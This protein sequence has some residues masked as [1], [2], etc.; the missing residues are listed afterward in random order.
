MALYVLL[1]GRFPFRASSAACAFEDVLRE[2][3]VAHA[4]PGGGTS[5]RLRS[6]VFR[7]SLRAPESGAHARRAAEMPI[8]LAD[9]RHG[10]LDPSGSGSGS[11]SGTASAQ[12]AISSEAR[13]LLDRMLSLTP[14]ARPTMAGVLAHP[15]SQGRLDPGHERVIQAL[16]EAQR[17]SEA[18]MGDGGGAVPLPPVSVLQ[19]E[20]VWAEALEK[21]RR[22][23]FLHLEPYRD[24]PY[25]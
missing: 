23:V 12:L 22:W 10:Q 19:T 16:R 25:E 15:W 13:D 24:G 8:F 1:M 5:D 20:V 14:A 3:A 6:Y 7:R 17:Q 21:L 9:G 11:G 18:H 4:S 2:I